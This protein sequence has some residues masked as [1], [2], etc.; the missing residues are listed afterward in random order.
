M[1]HGRPECKVDI[2]LAHSKLQFDRPMLR[3]QMRKETQFRAT[4]K[5]SHH[6]MISLIHVHLNFFAVDLRRKDS[7]CASR[8]IFPGMVPTQL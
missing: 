6:S 1:A 3:R 7:Q 2:T 5:G 8:Y 4:V